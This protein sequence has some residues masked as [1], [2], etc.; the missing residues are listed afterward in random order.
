MKMRIVLVG[1]G[2]LFS[3]L[4]QA[5]EERKYVREGNKLYFDGKLKEAEEMYDKAL[6]VKGDLVE[7]LFNKGNVYYQQDSFKLAADEYD[8]VAGYA[9]DK[10]VKAK[11]FHNKGTSLINAEDYEGAVEAFKDALRNDPTDQDTRYNLTYA[12]GKL[13]EQQE[14]DKQE[15]DQKQEKD[16]G[17]DKDKSQQ[18]QD[19]ET[20]PNKQDKEGQKNDKPKDPKEGE[21]GDPN[22]AKKSDEK[23]DKEKDMPVQ[24]REG[25]L[26]KA[27]AE[28]LL[29]AL[30]NEEEKVQLRLQKQEEKKQDKKKIEKDW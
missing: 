30:Q 29:E 9:N 10:K 14:Q 26:T 8:I 16:E 23:Q 20:D 24:P 21:N 4:V 13:K 22:D 25:Q 15:Q 19:Q 2:M 28:R 1:I 27:E 5:Q 3:L 7:G 12:M 18:N 17:E 6:T 11:A